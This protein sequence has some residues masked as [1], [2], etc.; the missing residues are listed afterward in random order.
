M[1][2]KPY[3]IIGL[4]IIL[5]FAATPLWLGN[6]GKGYENITKLLAKPKGKHCIESAQWMRAHHMVLLMEFRQMAVR[7]GIM[8]YRSHTYGVVY[9]T[10]FSQC[11]RC[12]DY[13][14]FCKRCHEF[15]GVSV[16]CWTCHTPPS[17]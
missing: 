14:E 2:H 12:H 5:A 11:F 6:S 8:H 17:K 9:N 4:I 16:Y 15:S 10:T 7:E 3:V 1:Y 13:K